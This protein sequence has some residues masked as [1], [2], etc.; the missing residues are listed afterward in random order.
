[1]ERA[2]SPHKA[3]TPLARS[4]MCLESYTVCERTSC[5]VHIVSLLMSSHRGFSL[6]HGHGVLGQPCIAHGGHRHKDA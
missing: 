2:E 1:M 4:T 6:M 5:G 3:V